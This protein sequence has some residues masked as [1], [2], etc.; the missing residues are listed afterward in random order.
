MLYTGER[1]VLIGVGHRNGVVLSKYINEILKYHKQCPKTWSKREKHEKSQRCISN[2]PKAAYFSK[3]P[4]LEPRK[5][6][7]N[8]GFPLKIVKK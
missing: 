4:V 5:I 1:G 7:Q 6:G 8:R 2:D 3:N